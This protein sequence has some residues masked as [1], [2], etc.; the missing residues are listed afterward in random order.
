MYHYWNPIE[1]DFQNVSITSLFRSEYSNGENPIAPPITLYTLIRLRTAFL[2]F[3]IALFF[4]GLLLTLIK[5][6]MNED[7]QSASKWEK[8]QHIIES[9]SMPEA[10]GDWDTDNDLDIDGHLKKWKKVLT[11]MLVM[12]LLQFVTN[13]CLLIPLFITGIPRFIF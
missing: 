10:Y 4:Y 8:L 1:D 11:E 12:V 9:L 7:F 3:W 2:L 13:I 5:Y 6:C